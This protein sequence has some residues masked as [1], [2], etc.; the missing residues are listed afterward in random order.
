[1]GFLCN[2]ASTAKHLSFG[3]AGLMGLAECISVTTN[4][5]KTLRYARK[6]SFGETSLVELSVEYNVSI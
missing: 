2:L 3:R 1:M 4:A 6:E 5:I